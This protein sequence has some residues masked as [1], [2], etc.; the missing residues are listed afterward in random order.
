MKPHVY[1]FTPEKIHEKLT[2]GKK[3]KPLYKRME[4][5]YFENFE[6]PEIAK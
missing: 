2:W 1:Y 6:L 3:K 4:D 5:D